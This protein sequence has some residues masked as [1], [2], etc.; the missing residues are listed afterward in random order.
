MVLFREP[1]VVAPV[2]WQPSQPGA[3]PALRR[4]PQIWMFWIYFRRLGSGW[5][6]LRWFSKEIPFQKKMIQQMQ[7]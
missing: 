2:L 6:L 1:F 7:V 3:V 5:S 4:E